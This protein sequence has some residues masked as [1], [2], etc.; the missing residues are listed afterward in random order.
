[1]AVTGG[2]ASD[3]VRVDPTVFIV[4]LAGAPEASPAF[5]IQSRNALRSESWIQEPVWHVV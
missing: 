5:F 4:V 3:A 1:M 2:V